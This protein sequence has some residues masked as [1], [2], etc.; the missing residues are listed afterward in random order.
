M[1]ADDFYFV[2]AIEGSRHQIFP[3][4]EIR[5]IAGRALIGIL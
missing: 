1:S 4:V 2:S 3:G 5:T